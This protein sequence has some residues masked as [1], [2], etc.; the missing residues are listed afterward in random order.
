MFS[1]NLVSSL[2]QTVE[3]VTKKEL[4]KAGDEFDQLCEAKIAIAD[5]VSKIGTNEQLDDLWKKADQLQ[6]DCLK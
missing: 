4:P 1:G 5:T 3:R 2:I 6:T